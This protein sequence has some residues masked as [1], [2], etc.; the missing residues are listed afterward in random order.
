MSNFSAVEAGNGNLV[1]MFGVITEFSGEGVNPKSGK[2]W[3]KAKIRD[4]AG[5][6]HSVT[7]RGELPLVTILN[8]RCEFSISTFKGTYQGQPYTGYSGFWQN[9]AQVKPQAQQ[10]AQQAS[11]PTPQAAGQAIDKKEVDWD[12]KDLRVARE[13]GLNNATKIICLLAEITKDDA[14]LE[15]E[16]VKRT[17]SILVDYIYNGIKGEAPILDTN[18]K[19][20]GTY[21]PELEDLKYSQ[22][23]NKPASDDDIPY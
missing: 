13:N 6:T 20:P 23:D 8:Q 11:Q 10:N 5:I 16:S 4:D 17:A 7:L 9:Q 18:S 19:Q 15:V 21:S 2:P 1:I 12:A 22:E 14:L 3:K